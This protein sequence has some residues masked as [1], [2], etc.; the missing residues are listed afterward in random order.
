MVKSETGPARNPSSAEEVL[1][2]ATGL[3]CQ[4]WSDVASLSDEDQ[5]NMDVHEENMCEE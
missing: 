5:D 3:E 1:A 4:E 2:A